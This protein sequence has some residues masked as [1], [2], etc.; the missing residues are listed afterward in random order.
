VQRGGCRVTTENSQVDA[1]L[2]SRLGA[3]IAPLLAAERSHDAEE[4]D[5]A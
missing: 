2:E 4:D 5:E 1:T 3:V